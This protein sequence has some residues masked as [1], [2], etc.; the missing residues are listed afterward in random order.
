MKNLS[1]TAKLKLQDAFSYAMSCLKEAGEPLLNGGPSQTY[2]DAHARMG[3]A[4]YAL[5]Q[6]QTKTHM[7][8]WDWDGYE[9]HFRFTWDFTAKLAQK[10]RPAYDTRWCG[11]S[12]RGHFDPSK[13]FDEE[14]AR[15]CAEAEYFDELGKAVGAW[16][17]A[18]AGK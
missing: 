5:L 2:A 14:L 7:A 16:A 15:L 4:L 3:R 8:E 13:P 9:G 12:A 6:A 11:L 10:N 18:K 1:K 17:Q